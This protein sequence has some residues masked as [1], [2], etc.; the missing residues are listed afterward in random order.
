MAVV[1]EPDGQYSKDSDCKDKNTCRLW[2]ITERRIVEVVNSPLPVAL[3]SLEP[4]SQQ[5]IKSS[6]QRKQT[7]FITQPQRD[8]IT[9]NP[10]QQIIFSTDHA[11]GAQISVSFSFFPPPR[12]SLSSCP[13]SADK[14]QGY[15]PSYQRSGVRAHALTP[16]PVGCE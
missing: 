4:V 5:F 3:S 14:R 10:R 13:L 8:I 1:N 11:D 15:R 12:I 2:N 6:R 7:S 9:S 16:G